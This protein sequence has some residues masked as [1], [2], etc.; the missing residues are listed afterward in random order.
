[1][2]CWIYI[3]ICCIYIQYIIYII[4][5]AVAIVLRS[6]PS[7]SSKKNEK[8]Q[9]RIIALDPRPCQRRNPKMLRRKS[10]K[11][12]WKIKR[13]P[14]DMCVSMLNPFFRGKK[15]RL[16]SRKKRSATRGGLSTKNS[17]IKGRVPA[18][19]KKKRRN[20]PDAESWLP[21]NSFRIMM[22]AFQNGYLNIAPFQSGPFMIRFW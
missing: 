16:W 9:K 8:T 13:Q 1:M 7:S 12:P 2:C 3:Y 11:N 5:A 17:S 22:D 18:S 6:S 14:A 15:N 21:L 20:P 10:T 4:V 19:P